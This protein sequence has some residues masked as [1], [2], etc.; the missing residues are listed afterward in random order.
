MV[1]FTDILN[2]SVFSN[3]VFYPTFAR[4]RDCLALQGTHA[5]THARTHALLF[6]TEVEAEAEGV[7]PATTP[8]RYVNGF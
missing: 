6:Y 5:R 2:F 3:L 8:Q 7:P 4:L 1:Y